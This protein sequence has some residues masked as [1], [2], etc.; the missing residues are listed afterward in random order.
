MISLL[1]TFPLPYPF[2]YF[3]FFFLRNEKVRVEM[4]NKIFERAETIKLKTP[5]SLFEAELFPSGA[6]WGG[7]ERKLSPTAFR[8][9]RL[10]QG[11]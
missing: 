4:K 5:N 2:I 8:L 3:F 9:K 1:V 7:R 6:E 10:P 11:F